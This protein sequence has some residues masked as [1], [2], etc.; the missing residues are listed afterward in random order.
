ME[1]RVDLWVTEVV[2]FSMGN[3]ES[4]APGRPDIYAGFKNFS[5]TKGEHEINISKPSR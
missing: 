3:S 4:D 2:C 5:P 1:V